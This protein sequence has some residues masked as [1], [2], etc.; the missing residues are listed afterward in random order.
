LVQPENVVLE[1]APEIPRRWRNSVSLK[2]FLNQSGVG[3]AREIEAGGGGWDFEFRG[4]RPLEGPGACAPG[5]N[6]GSVDIEQNNANHAA[7]VIREGRWN[8][9]STRRRGCIPVHR[10]M[11]RLPQSGSGKDV[12]DSIRRDGARKFGTDARDF[13]H[14]RI[15]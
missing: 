12:R 11:V 4:E 2:A 10:G 7:K 9:M 1:E 3:A 13:K 5:A 6:Q 14:L 8:A 15:H